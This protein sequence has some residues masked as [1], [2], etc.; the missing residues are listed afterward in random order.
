VLTTSSGVRVLGPPD[1]QAF[2]EL[3]AQE[4]VI[5]VF[6]DYRARTT[7]LDRRW[8]GGE[9]LGRFLDGQLV[10]A[11]HIGANLVPI[12]AGPYD[13][14][15][16]AD[17]LLPRKH[18]CA[19]LVG[20]HASVEA[21]WDLLHEKLGRPRETRWRQPHLEIGS[22]PLIE[23]DRDVRRTHQFDMDA[24][25]PACVAM[26]TE[27]VGISPEAGGGAALYRARVSQLISRGW[28]FARFDDSGRVIFKAEVACSSPYAAQVQGVYVPP[29]LRGQGLA[30]AGMAAVVAAVRAEI[31]PT[32]SLYVNDWN[33]SA[34]RAYAKV[35]FVETARFS[36][37][38]F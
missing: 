4:P 22:Y 13:L 11:L 14:E 12:Q 19:T 35:G 8:L 23:P 25:Y 28:S 27:E 10:A 16:F 1:L 6:A 2:L 20:P 38:M 7:Q 18:N 34:R 21:L 37:V 26:Y 31:A 15:A 9:V 30:T 5:N 32:V 17:M 24:L 3:T 33:E 36:T 29:E